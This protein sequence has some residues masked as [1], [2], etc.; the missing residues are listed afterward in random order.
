MNRKTLFSLISML[1]AFTLLLAA[2]APAATP[3]PPEPPPVST[4]APPAVTEAPPAKTVFKA[5]QV[6]DT[7]GIDDKSFN[8]TAWKGVEDAMKEFGIEGKYLESQQQTDYEKNINA[9]IDEGCNIIITVGFLLGD[10]TEAMAK[11]NP[12]QK[13]TIVDYAYDPPIPNVQGQIFS[14]EQAGFLAGYAAAA[15]SKTGKI[16]TFGGIQ[17]PTVTVFMDG[18]ALGAQYYNEKH[19]TNVEV[20]GWDPFAK[21][22]LFTGNFESTDDGRT[23]GETLM[24]EGADIIMPVAGPV[25]LGTA[26]AAKE[27]GNVYIIGVD[28]D[29]F[30]TA[31]DY[32]D[33]ILTSVMKYMDVTTMQSIK[34]AMDGTF[35]GGIIVGTLENGGLGLAPFHNLE[36]KVPAELM[37]E[38]DQVKADIISGAISAV[39]GEA[40]APKEPT[41]DIG[42]ADHPI[43]VLFVPSVDANQIIAGGEVMANALK[44]ATGLEFKVSVP[45]SYAATIEEMCASP[46]DTM[47]FIPAQGYVIANQLC[48]VDVAFK[49]I[50][51][52]WGVYW[53]MFVVPRDSK[54]QTLA[55]LDGLK[56]AY[57]D[58]GSTSGYL[59]PQIAL[60]N[61]GATPGETLEAGGHPEAIRAVY[62][63]EADFG[64]AFYSAPLKPE[65]EAPWAVGDDPD[66]PADLVE[67]CA[68]SADGEALMCGEW[69]VLDARANLRTEAPDVIQKVRILALT[70]PIPNDTLSFG[71]DFPPELRAAIE[72]ALVAFSKSDAW[73]QSIGSEDFYSWSGLEVAHDEEYDIVRQL[74][75]FLGITLKDLGK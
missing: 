26:A 45:T 6:T 30:L 1:A 5:C 54:A 42:T 64:T 37:A 23:M 74:V 13:F 8:A 17:I 67:S 38:L 49:A 15:L 20:L 9:F 25:G 31:P 12:D 62:N 44:E 14:T 29:W 18:Y 34:E 19:N 16:G 72:K 56:W 43:K 10:A 28:S 53:A 27:R 60:N 52:G 59:F 55:D 50:R 63:G 61:A 11:A 3:A 40:P 2:C 32:A 33:I 51:R 69:R 39:P 4:E 65:G 71:P 73:F 36:S 21:T 58:A 35:Q 75:D 66:V 41:T 70:D 48:G 7:G 24:D 57:P 22:G 47:G 68:P 46:E